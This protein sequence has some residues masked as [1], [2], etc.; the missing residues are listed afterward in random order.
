M[1]FR[2]R[3]HA[4]LVPE[5]IVT[6]ERLLGLAQIAIVPRHIQRFHRHLERFAPEVVLFD[7]YDELGEGD[8]A[9]ISAKDSIFVFTHELQDFISRIWPRLEG[10]DYVVLT[11]NS[12][13][14]AD[15][16][17]LPWLDGSGEKLS[18]W[19]AQNLMIQHPK[20]EPL[21]IGIANS[22]WKHGNLRTM[23]RAIG[24]AER[25]EKSR[26]IH[27]RFNPKTHPGRRQASEALS[28]NFPDAGDESSSSKRFGSYLA[29]LARHRF[30]ACPRGNGIDTHRFWE[31][32]YLGVIPVV[33]R[34]LQSEHWRKCG[35]PLLITQDWSEVT[36]D[37][38]EEK[39]AS[40]PDVP[41]R[42]PL[43]LSHYS[44]M[45]RDA[46]AANA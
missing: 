35:L 29:D 33:E 41:N 24:R 27:I 18:R 19:F 22:M 34:S 40:L 25:M 4:W 11:H 37:W 9:R 8:L 1:T 39:A 36:P 12:D 44:R 7:D 3:S 45:I 42:D 21:P 16:R 46:V 6:G 20:T 23:H 2:S 14:E 13:Y 38:L 43:R 15:S 30:C 31:S 10:R 28:R 26:L 17:Y 32:Q 5:E